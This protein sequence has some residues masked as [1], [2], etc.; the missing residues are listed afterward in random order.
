MKVTLYKRNTNSKPIYWTVEYN[1]TNDSIHITHGIVNKNS[2]HEDVYTKRNKL[3]EIKSM[4]D[5]KRKQGYKELSELY[6]NAPSSIDNTMLYNYLN[7]YLPKNNTD[8]NGNFI[9]M[10]CKTLENN[11]PFKK[12]FYYGQYKINGERCIITA[13]KDSDLFEEVHLHYRSREGEDWTNKLS[14]L[15]DYL[16]PKITGE[17]LDMMLE[18]DI[19]LDGEMYIPGYKI[20]EI[21]SIIK[22]NNHPQHF[23][24]QYWLYDLCIDDKT[25]IDRYDILEKNLNSYKYHFESE[26]EHLNNKNKLVLL[27]NTYQID[28][29]DCC[30][31]LR[32]QFINCGF[33]GLVIRK[34]DSLYQFGG[35]RNY[36]MLKFKKIY[37]GKFTIIDIIPIS[38]KQKNMGKLILQNDIN[39]Q[40]FECTINATHEKQE[41]I[42]Q[43]KENYIGKLAFVEYRERSGVTEVPFHA[44]VIKI[45]ND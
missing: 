30:I 42:L 39:N 16:I 29:Y 4:I 35:K 31:T 17:L 36:S 20:N 1:S 8:D 25:A 33:E 24:L 27:P 5:F 45:L 3:D 7:T 22:N 18:E 19:A 2:I 10:F 37:D 26:V 43:N 15:D 13:E 14:Y 38:E 32:D 23:N 40:W 41:E 34:Y 12:G 28:S 44:K 11:N 21:N 9:P 6:D